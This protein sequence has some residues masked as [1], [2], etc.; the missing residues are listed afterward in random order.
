MWEDESMNKRDLNSFGK[1]L[2]CTHFLPPFLNLPQLFSQ[3][4]NPHTI[5]IPCFL[6]LSYSASR[7][8]LYTGQP[9]CISIFLLLIVI[10]L[11][12]RT[13]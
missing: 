1:S 11:S 12:L 6:S 3:S 13:N 9:P 4:S 2:P 5:S 7:Q 10:L 8:G